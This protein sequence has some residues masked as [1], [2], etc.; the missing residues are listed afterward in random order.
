MHANSHVAYRADID[1]LRAVA[2]LSV[3][4]FHAFPTLLPGGFIGVDIF[5]VISGYLIS[6]ILMKSADEG[7]FSVIDFY[8]RRIRRILPPLLAMLILVLVIGWFTLLPNEYALLS[9]HTVA[10]LGFVSNIIFWQEAG[11]FD[12]AAALKPLLHLWSLG[13]EEQFYIIW[14]PIL[15]I[16][17]KRRWPMPI[18]LAV[19]VSLSFI[20][21]LIMTQPGSVTGYFLL[22]ARAWELLV[23]AALAG[24]L[25]YR[26]PLFVTYKNGS[27]V[28][29]CIGLGLI[30]AALY[31][32]DEEKNFP[33]GWA[34][35]PVL[36][37][38]LLIIAG[39][40]SLT[41]RY[42][43]AQRAMVAIGLISFPLYLWH[44]PLLSFAWI[45]QGENI[46]TGALLALLG[47]AFILATLS[48]LLIEKPIRRRTGRRS[49]I[50]IIVI[51]V[52]V[53]LSAANIFK[54]D[55]L[56]FRLQ[57]K[58][59]AHEAQALQ[60]SDA[61]RSAPDCRWPV[62]ADI[63]LNCLITDK[64]R[65]PDAVIIGDS[66]ANHY[67]WGL[68][69]E[70]GALGVN[71]LQLSHSGCGP[72]YDVRAKE[73]TRD[74][75][76]SHFM[77]AAINYIAAN[78]NIH[79][80]FLAGRWMLY[81]TGREQKHPA[82]HLSEEP[83]VTTDDPH[84]TRNLSRAEVVQRGLEA[85]LNRLSAQGKKI[86]FLHAVPELP[87]NARECLSWSP[88]RFVSR[89]VRPDCTADQRIM[90]QR[91]AEFRPVL[92]RVLARYPHVAQ[93]DP[94]PLLCDGTHCY[95]RKEGLLLYRD[96]D[97]LSLDGSLWIA[98]QMRTQLPKWLGKS[99]HCAENC[100]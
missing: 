76:C 56:D 34:L 52:L 30:A 68:N 90:E 40:Q 78:P 94:V 22:P 36:G 85:S 67:Y 89:A 25:R 53:A 7:R 82:G 73:G 31:L 47:L 48:Y 97:H 96:D 57:N 46:S 79:T 24:W 6:S 5:F 35:L 23:G 17:F 61:R 12:N 62:T 44:W 51:V 20:A 66:H 87:Y 95:G 84:G 91:A 49:M 74:I 37:A 28:A 75:D 63:T 83:L 19:L 11:Y 26:G 8:A 29:G 50:S 71:L 72:L 13:V 98:R 58:Q 45:L 18:V 64:T 55:G 42:F 39:E 81:L 4:I 21:N 60:W 3:L 2:V 99:D 16:A 32:I 93:F 27:H 86:V 69:Q 10:G 14:P 33:G 65:Q 100:P 77:N 59:A 80:V 88:N 15:L 92:A 43:L 70:L 38:A 54:R 1:G 9:K 41:S